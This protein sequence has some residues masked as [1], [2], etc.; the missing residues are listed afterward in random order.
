MRL[1]K[2]Q[3]GFNLLEVLV[4]FAIAAVALSIQMQV[5]SNGFQLSKTAEDYSRATVIAESLMAQIGTEFTQ[6]D[7][8][9][10]GQFN[11]RFNWVVTLSPYEEEGL[12]LSQN[13]N[14]LLMNIAFDIQWSEG[15]KLR[16]YSV[17]SL[18]LVS[19]RER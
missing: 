13:S 19:N 16:H 14:L 15:A 2:H 3:R 10:S 8:P 18:R 5:F 11:D 12:E 7:S 1:L 4:A 9:Y 6:Q 17:S